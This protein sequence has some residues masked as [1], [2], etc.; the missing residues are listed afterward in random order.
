[1]SGQNPADSS[2]SHFTDEHFTPT[3]ITAA[4][5]PVVTIVDN[6]FTPMQAIR[7][8]NFVSYPVDR[9]T[10]MEQLNNKIF[11]VQ[12]ITADTF[13]LY[14]SN[15]QAIDG[16]GFTTFVNNGL[17]Q[18]TLVGPALYVDNPAPPP[19]SGVPAF[20]PV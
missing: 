20:P 9:S 6:G 2:P 12:P 16:R 10:G 14:D 17:A 8:T 3:A 13:G 18:M 11:Y 19:P 5:P 1:M 15:A 7:C 4:W